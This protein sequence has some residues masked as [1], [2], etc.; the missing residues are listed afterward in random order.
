M[1]GKGIRF[2]LQPSL[3]DLGVSMK[4]RSSMILKM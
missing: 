1:T 2:F 3:E 4:E